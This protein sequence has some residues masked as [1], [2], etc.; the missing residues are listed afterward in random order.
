VPLEHDLVTA[1]NDDL[2]RIET[3]EKVHDPTWG[4]ATGS[5]SKTAVRAT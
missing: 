4:M 3:R 2:L 1:L 5:I